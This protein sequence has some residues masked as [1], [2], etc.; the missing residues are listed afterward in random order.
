MQLAVAAALWSLFPFGAKAQ[1]AST[2]EVPIQVNLSLGKSK[3][4]QGEP[5][6]LDYELTNRTQKVVPLLSMQEGRFLWLTFTLRDA[7]GK[8]VRQGP[9]DLPTTNLVFAAELKPG[10]AYK[11]RV[12]V[13]QWTT[14]PRPGQY[15][16]HILATLRYERQGP[17]Q[18]QTQSAETTLPLTVDPPDPTALRTIAAKLFT[19][20]LESNR[21]EADKAM[22]ALFSMSAS[23]AQST[24]RRLATDPKTRGFDGRRGQVIVRLARLGT[25]S[26]VNVLSAVWR[27]RQASEWGMAARSALVDLY[28]NKPSLRPFIGQIFVSCEGAPPA[29]PGPNDPIVIDID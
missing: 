9:D 10:A 3:V 17:T 27:D 22:D 7:E 6:F 15:T 20:C 14:P 16:L 18:F 1:N 2:A 5:I 25:P 11:D 28:R 26:A 23:A 8:T 4:M 13:S 29:L 12:A 24:W 19:T 21:L